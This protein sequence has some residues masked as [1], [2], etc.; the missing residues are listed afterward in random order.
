MWKYKRGKQSKT[1]SDATGQQHGHWQQNPTRTEINQP[2]S[3][4]S[5]IYSSIQP[6][7][8]FPFTSQLWSLHLSIHPT[9]PSI[10]LLIHFNIHLSTMQPFISYF[11]HLLS[12]SHPSTHCQSFIYTWF[13]SI[14]HQSINYLSI[15]PLIYSLPIYHPF[16]IHLLLIDYLSIYPTISLS[17]HPSICLYFHPYYIHYLSFIHSLIYHLSVIHT[18]IHLSILLFIQYL[19]INLF[20]PYLAFLLSMY[21]Y[22]PCPEND[23]QGQS[24]IR[25]E[26]LKSLCLLT[27]IGF[28][29]GLLW[30][31]KSHME[32][33]CTDIDPFW[34]GKK[35]LFTERLCKFTYIF[36]CYWKHSWR[37]TWTCKRAATAEKRLI[38][39]ILNCWKKEFSRF[40]MGSCIC[41]W[42]VRVSP[43]YTH[44]NKRAF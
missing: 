27:H 28:L 21:P 2:F 41:L 35:K 23:Q 11:F 26:D 32:V 8:V 25:M 4:Q 13:H 44:L 9:H 37:L 24:R 38:E 15:D 16:F 40:Y 30:M 19:S 3:I 17:I 10:H 31:K 1:F 29:L 14:I 18:S 42:H 39:L 22:F 43:K 7:L 5:L 36:R 12:I 20:N 34:N 6:F 33:Y